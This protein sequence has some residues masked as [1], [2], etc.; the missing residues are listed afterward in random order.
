VD[1]P[2]PELSGPDDL[3]SAAGAWL[4]TLEGAEERA[5]RVLALARY[6]GTSARRAAGAARAD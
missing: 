2:A 5:R 4:T 1:A 3:I 6:R